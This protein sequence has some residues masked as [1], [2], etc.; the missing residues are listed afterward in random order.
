[1]GT[2]GIV[3]A[4]DPPPEPLGSEWQKVMI[5]KHRAIISFMDTDYGL[6]TFRGQAENLET[7][8]SG[9]YGTNVITTTKANLAV[10]IGL[11]S[12]D[13]RVFSQS[14]AFGLVPQTR[15]IPDDFMGT[16]TFTKVP[17]GVI[18]TSYLTRADADENNTF[19]WM[20][21]TGRNET[22]GTVGR[23]GRVLITGIHRPYYKYKFKADLSK[24]TLPPWT[25]TWPTTWLPGT[26]TRT[27]TRTG[28]VN[29]LTN[30]KGSDDFEI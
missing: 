23:I 13:S 1:M 25:R 11:L 29:F 15:T 16:Q 20:E 2:A 30:P 3:S 27:A 10:K 24:Y 26:G 22:T 6:K 17:T 7:D 14:Q 21:L 8:L 18:C 9:Y 5:T 19:L 28:W 4:E 12:L